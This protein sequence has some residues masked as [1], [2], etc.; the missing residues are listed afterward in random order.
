MESSRSIDARR[1]NEIEA[2]KVLSEARLI[3]DPFLDLEQDRCLPV[4]ELGDLVKLEYSASECVYVSSIDSINYGVGE[5]VFTCGG[6]RVVLRNVLLGSSPSSD[7]ILRP[8]NQD[9]PLRDL[10]GCLPASRPHK[11]GL[12][13]STPLRCIS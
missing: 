2:T 9:E 6:E 4:I 7:D 3:L 11:A 13:T 10:L 1:D 8:T 5:F 12:S